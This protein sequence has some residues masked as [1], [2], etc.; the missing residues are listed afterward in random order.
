MIESYKKGIA[1]C[2]DPVGRYVNDNVMLTNGVVCL[3]DGARAREIATRQNRGYLY[4][5]VCLY[6]DT[7]PKPDWAPVW[8]QPPI[9]LTPDLV[10]A[11]IAGGSLLCGTPEEVVGQLKAYEETGVDQVAFGFP[12]D[13]SYDEAAEVIEVFGREVIPEF[14]RDP[15][16]R[17]DVFRAGAVPL[18]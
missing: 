10:D 2:T 13:L 8:P 7:I 11:A 15:V 16:H 14:D 9:R 6:H 5:L 3:E 4:S 18:G 1:E 17:T 12:N